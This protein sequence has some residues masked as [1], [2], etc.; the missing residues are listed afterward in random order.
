MF[1]IAQGRTFKQREILPFLGQMCICFRQT[2]FYS[3]GIVRFL[4]LY[5]I[6]IFFRPVIF[7]KHQLYSCSLYQRVYFLNTFLVKGDTI[8]NFP[9]KSENK[10]MADIVSMVGC[11]ACSIIMLPQGVTIRKSGINILREGE[12]SK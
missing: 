7:Q 9:I 8:H 3:Y 4:Y 5:N 2:L 6:L 1:I 12:V 10:L 11:C